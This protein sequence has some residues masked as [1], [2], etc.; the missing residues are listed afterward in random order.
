M[1]PRTSPDTANQFTQ[2]RLCPT[3]FP[4]LNISTPSDSASPQRPPRRLE[5]VALVVCLGALLILSIGIWRR[6]QAGMTGMGRSANTP[7][8]ACQLIAQAMLRDDTTTIKRLTTAR[9]YASL[10]KIRKQGRF[11][12]YPKLGRRLVAEWGRP[13]FWN[14]GAMNAL[15]ATKGL[16]RTYKPGEI[17]PELRMVR[18]KASWKLDSYVLSYARQLKPLS[19]FGPVWQLDED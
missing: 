6:N 12:T 14:S 15:G 2:A 19:Q 1:K 5:W 11:D 4:P 3:S 10:Q 17:R 13:I 8:G 16:S 7:E 18:T 9:G